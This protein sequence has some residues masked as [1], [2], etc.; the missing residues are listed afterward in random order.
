LK[1][2]IKQMMSDRLNE[3]KLSHAY[4]I[5]GD[6]TPDMLKEIAQEILCENKNAC[7]QCHACKKVKSDNHPDLLI[8]LPD[9]SSIKNNQIEAFQNF[10]MIKP[11]ES[12]YKIALFTDLELMTERA[13]NRLLKILEEP[14]DYAIIIFLTTNIEAVLET[15]RSRCQV[16]NVNAFLNE[17]ATKEMP[18]PVISF[19]NSMYYKD[20]NRILDFAIFA[21][22]DKNRFSLFLESLL[23]SLRD[24][25]VYKE[26]RNE[27]L[28]SNGQVAEIYLSQVVALS[29]Q[30]SF[31][32][33][34]GAMTSIELAKQ[35]LSNNMNFDLTVE[36]LLFE[37]ID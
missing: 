15:I 5:N 19:L 22:E 18:E 32:Q 34:L 31:K 27:Q 4:I 36:Q 25:A 35:K 2:N 3:G 8:T 37:C 10:M 1:L 29:D 17:L 33:L 9:G 14:P 26:T 28:I 23:Q 6:Y 30:L 13:Q 24:I 11:F 7:G 20:V 12:N 16:L 21:K